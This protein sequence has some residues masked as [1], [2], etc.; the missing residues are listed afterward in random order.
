MDVARTFGLRLP[1]RRD[2][3][4]FNS[5]LEAG[6]AGCQ[7]RS[8]DVRSFYGR[9]LSRLSQEV[10]VPELEKKYLLTM[11]HNQTEIVGIGIS[12][13]AAVLAGKIGEQLYQARTLANMTLEIG[14]KQMAEDIQDIISKASKMLG[15]KLCPNCNMYHEPE[16][17]D[18]EERDAS[19]PTE[20]ES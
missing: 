3:L 17:N 2:D 14:E 12:Y 4:C 8:N 15:A 20:T 11:N 16:D 10:T 5:G 7:C 1:E 18:H 19:A 6:R 9:K 13:V